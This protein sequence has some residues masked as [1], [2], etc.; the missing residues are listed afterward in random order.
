MFE[1]GER[2]FRAICLRTGGGR[3]DRL[4]PQ[5]VERKT[6]GPKCKSAGDRCAVERGKAN[7]IWRSGNPVMVLKVDRIKKHIMQIRKCFWL[8]H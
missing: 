7:P 3:T 2:N 6:N 5:L 8:V 4:R 1:A